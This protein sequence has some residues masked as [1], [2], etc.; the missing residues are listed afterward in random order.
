MKQRSYQWLWVKIFHPGSREDVSL[1]KVS[2]TSAR[3]P[4]FNALG[5]VVLTGDPS[6][7]EVRTDLWVPGQPV[8][9]SQ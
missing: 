1:S 4:V 3:G 8:Y 5:T 9:L 7:E 6:T 2:A